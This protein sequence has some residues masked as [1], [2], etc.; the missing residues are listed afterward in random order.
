MARTKAQELTGE[1]LKK[2]A[3]EESLK[4]EKGKRE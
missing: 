2:A 1:E 3:E 4:T